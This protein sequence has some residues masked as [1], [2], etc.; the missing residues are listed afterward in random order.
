VIGVDEEPEL[1]DRTASSAWMNIHRSRH[2]T[3]SLG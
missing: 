1:F 3:M 2:D